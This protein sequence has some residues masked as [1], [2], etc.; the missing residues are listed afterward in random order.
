[1]TVDYWCRICGAHKSKS[2][3]TENAVKVHIRK[4][5][6]IDQMI[7]FCLDPGI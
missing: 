2:Y 4:T 1:M 7:N 6:T 3:C 5:H